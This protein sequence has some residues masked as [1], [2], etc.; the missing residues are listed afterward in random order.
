MLK[1]S[2]VYDHD[3]IKVMCGCFQKFTQHINI[4]YLALQLSLSA[5]IVKKV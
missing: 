3:D 5:E 2:K 1:H 4:F